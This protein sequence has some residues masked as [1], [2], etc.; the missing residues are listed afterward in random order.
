MDETYQKTLSNS[1]DEVLFGNL[2]LPEPLLQLVDPVLV[3]LPSNLFNN[4]LQLQRP[5]HSTHTSARHHL[6]TL[7]LTVQ[8]LLHHHSTGVM[9]EITCMRTAE[10]THR[11]CS[12]GPVLG[13]PAPSLADK[14]LRVKATSLHEN[15]NMLQE[16]RALPSS[17]W[18]VIRM[19][20]SNLRQG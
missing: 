14:L 20:H 17:T 3:S 9:D 8:A 16:S 7:M 2:P 15:K 11:I 10:A 5:R 19:H 18:L 1:K 13:A 6:A 12:K 4:E